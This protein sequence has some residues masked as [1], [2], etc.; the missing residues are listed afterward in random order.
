MSWTM[1]T[2]KKM[3]VIKQLIHPSGT[4]KNNV[5]IEQNVDMYQCRHE[6]LKQEAEQACHTRHTV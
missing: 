4:P 2:T 1:C 3:I 5:H 6:K